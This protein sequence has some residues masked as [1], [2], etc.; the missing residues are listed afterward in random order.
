MGVLKPRNR[1]VYFRVS[2]EE[3]QSLRSYCETCGARSVSDLARSAV[4]GAV[5]GRNPVSESE[6]L[7]TLREIEHN[8]G[9][10]SRKFDAF[11]DAKAGIRGASPAEPLP[12]PAPP[13]GKMPE[14][15]WG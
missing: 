6:L 9:R 14:N 1:I 12:A 10:L 2:E 8:I 15:V 13:A 7:T 11:S 3:F 4:L 5:Q